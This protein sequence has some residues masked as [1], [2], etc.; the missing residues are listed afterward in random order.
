MT[1]NFLE[2][3]NRSLSRML[4]NNKQ[5]A[6]NRQILKPSDSP[7][8][9]A[10]SL[11]FQ[12]SIDLAA[13]YQR[14]I[15]GSK[16]WLDLAD[17]ELQAMSS[18]TRSLKNEYAIA[19]SSDSMSPEARI[20][21]SNDVNALKNELINLA[22][23][24]HLDRYIFAGYETRTKPFEE[25]KQ[26][27]QILRQGT[28][29]GTAGAV[30]YTKKV[31]SDLPELE[32]GDYEI[33]IN[34]D[35]QSRVAIASLRNVAT[36]ESIAL[37]S[38]GSDDSG[39][40]NMN[41]L[42]TVSRYQ[43]NPGDF[44]DTGRGIAVEIPEGYRDG[45]RIMFS[46]SPGDS[47]SYQGDDG[48]IK[49]QIGPG[50]QIDINVT[51]G[52]IFAQTAKYI[53][54]T[55]GNNTSGQPLKNISLFSEIDKANVQTGN[56]IDISG[57]D[58]SGNRIGSATVLSPKNALLSQ[59]NTSVDQRTLALNYSTSTLDSFSK[60][61][62]LP[63][64]GYQNHDRLAFALQ[65]SINET[66]NPNA[67]QPVMFQG[68][69]NAAGTDIPTTFDN[70]G[71]ITNRLFV[72]GN[73]AYDQH[74]QITIKAVN[75]MTVPVS[76]SNTLTFQIFGFEQKT[77]YSDTASLTS[78]SGSFLGT[79]TIDNPMVGFKYSLKDDGKISGNDYGLNIGFLSNQAFSAGS[80]FDFTMSGAPAM[81]LSDTAG[82][83]VG[84]DLS[85]MRLQYDNLQYTNPTTGQSETI[86]NI[87][88]SASATFSPG[89]TPAD[90]NYA[91]TTNM[92]VRTGTISLGADAYSY[93]VQVPD[94]GL[95]LH[96]DN[97]LGVA[98][99][100]AGNVVTA[101]F[102]GGTHPAPYVDLTGYN[103]P[104][105]SVV[106]RFRSGVDVA[107]TTA[108]PENYSS[109]S[110]IDF[111][112][113]TIKGG[114]FD[115]LDN[116]GN[117]QQTIF[118]SKDG[119]SSLVNGATITLS[120][121]SKFSTGDLL[122]FQLISENSFNVIA[123]GSNLM[124]ETRAIG[125]DISF[126]VVADPYSSLGFDHNV[127]TTTGLNTTYV[128][129]ENKPVEDMLK[130]I[131]NLYGNT[132]D[133]FI[134]ENG[135]LAFLD[136]HPGATKFEIQVVSNNEGVKHTTSLGYVNPL[137]S[138]LNNYYI[139]GKYAARDDNQWSIKLNAPNPSAIVGQDNGITLTVEDK[140][141]NKLLE[142]Y[143]LDAYKATVG[144]SPYFGEEIYV[145][146]GLSIRIP[147]GTVVS[148]YQNISEIQL[149]GNGGLA[150][151]SSATIINGS[152]V[153]VFRSI[154]NLQEA[155]AL[156]LGQGGIKAP[157]DWSF[158]SV[159]QPA[160]VG[161]FTG[162]YNSQWN[163]EVDKVYETNSSTSGIKQR[164]EYTRS[165][166]VS[167]TDGTLSAYNPV[168]ERYHLSAMGTLNIAY[169]D[170]AYGGSANISINI[171]N[172]PTNG[173]FSSLSEITDYIN[174]ELKKNQTAVNNGI[175]VQ[176]AGDPKKN[177]PV[178]FKVLTNGNSNVNAVT[179]NPSGQP[180]GELGR[181]NGLFGGSYAQASG[182]AA[183][184][185]GF[186]VNYNHYEFD[187]RTINIPYLGENIGLVVEDLT[188]PQSASATLKL[189][190]TK[191][192]DGSARTAN[193]IT[194][195][196]TTSLQQRLDDHFGGPGSSPITAEINTALS[197]MT[198]SFKQGG[199]DITGIDDSTQNLFGLRKPGAG[200]DY[201]ITDSQGNH[202]RK[203][204]VH[205]AFDEV[206]IR[207]GVSITMGEGAVVSKDRFSTRVG[208]GAQGEIN[209]LENGL[210][211]ILSALS[212]VGSTAYRLE[213]THERYESFS[214]MRKDFITAELKGTTQDMIEVAS[215]LE[216]NK[217]TYESALAMYGKSSKL[218]LLNFI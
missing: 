34:Y 25:T 185:F 114:F 105:E 200:V 29:I 1:S 206:Y 8:R 125:D 9:V 188:K 11:S 12:N 96:F 103:G 156:D 28:Y 218:T 162:N 40:D 52:E 121:D 89:D 172:S 136:K 35:N 21:L 184:N 176:F 158:G 155:L 163:F 66:I 214:I 107:D 186:E 2:G 139:S 56:T 108:I 61:V 49:S 48:K 81:A 197:P 5:I 212:H 157:S 83:L 151:G 97:S 181:D 180:Y 179:V 203:V 7:L 133:A 91:I 153:D 131:E 6:G 126:S 44:I 130:F 182:D 85:G 64:G 138:E 174:S 55:F 27:L 195:A 111:S 102:S 42:T 199:K 208:V 71:V 145:A 109:A 16:A 39:N 36:G 76:A 67:N 216:R 60:N 194:T 140:Y 45:Q 141:G 82:D 70:G 99:F 113:P 118:I 147:L 175:E 207:D 190:F 72:T 112:D 142:N 148:N 159:A 14:N 134:T 73:I 101:D 38:N 88:F 168:T 75:D 169:Y 92:G 167:S 132:I 19:G 152:G 173:I 209:H 23:A 43:A 117:L 165:S 63:P 20:A 93:P 217:T 69:K 51:G 115:V 110:T 50:D 94:T 215:T 22:N 54:T 100:N 135:K 53:E 127:I 124:L 58:H 189:D 98:T 24:K 17:G 90:L 65:T 129:D 143:P 211:Q 68:G 171:S 31:F 166:D 154:S 87:E 122:S 146:N 178:S 196:M 106:L 213:L 104:G 74:Q 191:N 210:D 18:I 62:T 4:E 95:S 41:R 187:K 164:S 32:K 30:L 47:L 123:D 79:M 198:L 57:F 78:A 3:V 137:G 144:D 80:T 201:K 77:E 183:V 170:P 13:Q 205:S 37:D 116:H 202:I 150:F 46:Y 33:M 160:L 59:I 119:R 128:I 84:G 120:P 161:E 15:T 192:A 204:Y 10:N 149:K 86:L 193:E 177:E 26:Q